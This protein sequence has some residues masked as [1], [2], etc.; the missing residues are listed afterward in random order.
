MEHKLTRQIARLTSEWKEHGK[1]IIGVD[2]D[3]T[4]KNWKFEDYETM[5][6]VM[7]TVREA[8]EIGAY[9]VLFSACS[10]DRYPEMQAYCD[11]HGIVLDAI[12]KNPIALPY[13]NNGK[14]YA[15]IFLDDRAG[16]LEALDILEGAMANM[17]ASKHGKSDNSEL[18]QFNKQPYTT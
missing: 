17:R 11:R 18:A 13:G 9:I 6:R 7:Q 14:I 5:D 8:R 3:D 1:I 15:N 12:N 10:E 4:I 16:I 2:Y